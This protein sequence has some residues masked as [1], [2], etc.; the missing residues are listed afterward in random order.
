MAAIL[1]RW[2]DGFAPTPVKYSLRTWRYNETVDSQT[3]P[4]IIGKACRKE[5]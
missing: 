5:R 4:A 1:A 2:T 3:G